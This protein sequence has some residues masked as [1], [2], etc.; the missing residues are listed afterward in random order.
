MP[1]SRPRRGRRTV[2]DAAAENELDHRLPRRR[3][4]RDVADR[5]APLRQV[6][7]REIADAGRV[8]E[9]LEMRVDFL[10]VSVNDA[11]RLEDPVAALRAQFADAQGRGLRVD[12][13]E[14]VGEVRAVGIRIDGLD[15]EGE[16]RG[17]A[18]SLRGG[19]TH[20]DVAVR[21]S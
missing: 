21:L 20:P 17:H 15:H 7:S 1:R 10:G 9:P 13:S 12:G 2:L 5:S 6:R 18:M 11:D 4:G 16:T 3:V 14:G 19:N 8:G